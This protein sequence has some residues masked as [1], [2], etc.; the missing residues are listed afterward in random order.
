MWLAAHAAVDRLHDE[1]DSSSQS[2]L[3]EAEQ[4]HKR[5]KRPADHEEDKRNRVLDDRGK[6]DGYLDRLY[7]G[8]VNPC[9]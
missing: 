2:M 7:P 1:R 6:M 5:T 8:E 3:D 9:P 4:E